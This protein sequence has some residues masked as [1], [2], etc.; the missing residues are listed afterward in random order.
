[1][2]HLWNFFLGLSFCLFFLLACAPAHP[3]NVENAIENGQII[4]R[5]SYSLYDV[6]R[7]ILATFGGVATTIL[8]TFLKNKYPKYFG[9]MKIPDNGIT[10]DNEKT[11]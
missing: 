9:T 6:V 1:M 7:L 2:K 8:L 5:V 11:I 10:R 3:Q 4:Q